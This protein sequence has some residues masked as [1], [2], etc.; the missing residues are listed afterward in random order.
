[1]FP[2]WVLILMCRKK[3]FQKLCFPCPMT[4]T[5]IRNI[6]LLWHLP[7]PLCLHGRLLVQSRMWLC[8]TLHSQ[9]SGKRRGQ[10]PAVCLQGSGL[11][12]GTRVTKVAVQRGVG[13]VNTVCVC[14][15]KTALMKAFIYPNLTDVACV[16][17][18]DTVQ[19][20]PHVHHSSSLMTPNISMLNWP[21]LTKTSEKCSAHSLQGS[22]LSKPLRCPPPCP[23]S[24]GNSG[25]VQ[26]TDPW[27]P[28]G[29]LSTDQRKTSPYGSPSPLKSHTLQLYPR[30]R[31]LMVFSA[32]GE[33]W[34]CSAFRRK[35]A[36]C[37]GS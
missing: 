21:C 24:C 7:S 19:A 28:L 9:V 14:G 1:M 15:W 27:C 35:V 26:A 12:P 23:L 17:V 30:V 8:A 22:S 36:G 5:K 11:R 29:R 37:H 34:F 16:A 10:G 20:I 32:R 18:L 2:V 6:C 13:Q 3:N 25:F 4:L 33:R 31:E